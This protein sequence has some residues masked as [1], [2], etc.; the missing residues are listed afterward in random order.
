MKNLPIVEVVFDSLILDDEHGEL[1][2]SYVLA[3]EFLTELESRGFVVSHESRVW[4]KS[5]QEWEKNW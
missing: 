5:A 2:T 4:G 3:K 1:K